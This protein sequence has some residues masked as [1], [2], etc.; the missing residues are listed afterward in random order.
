MFGEQFHDATERDSEDRHSRAADEAA[1]VVNPRESGAR[2]I[3]MKS[4]SKS[5]YVGKKRPNALRKLYGSKSSERRFA[6]RRPRPF[7]AL[8]VSKVPYKD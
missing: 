3:I 8:Q 5:S 2:D 6:F 1:D 4:G 7:L